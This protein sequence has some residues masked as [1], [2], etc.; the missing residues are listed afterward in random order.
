MTLSNA[1][2]VGNETIDIKLDLGKYYLPDNKMRSIY[3]GGRI[4]V[5]SGSFYRDIDNIDIDNKL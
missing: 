1:Q 5:E 2:L 4:A 3:N